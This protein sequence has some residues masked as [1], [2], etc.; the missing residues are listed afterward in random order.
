MDAQLAGR[1]HVQGTNTW[2]TYEVDEVFISAA[3]T[4]VGSSTYQCRYGN[5]PV[6][7]NVSC[8]YP[9]GVLKYFAGL[10]F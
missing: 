3:Y 4:G 10:G 6:Y 8:L 2:N 1:T 7:V 9:Y 5:P